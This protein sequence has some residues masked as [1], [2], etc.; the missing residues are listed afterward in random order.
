MT[1]RIGEVQILFLSQILTVSKM[2]VAESGLWRIYEKEPVQR[3]H[4]TS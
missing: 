1:P 3:G 2:E 4:A